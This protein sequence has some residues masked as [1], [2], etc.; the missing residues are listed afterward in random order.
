MTG[1]LVRIGFEVIDANLDPGAAVRIAVRRWRRRDLR[2]DF[3]NV[4]NVLDMEATLRA[5]LLPKD[6]TRRW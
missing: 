4:V 6:R 1:P 2:P 3:P 5:G